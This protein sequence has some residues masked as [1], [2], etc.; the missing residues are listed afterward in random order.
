LAAD[1]AS[2]A[3]KCFCISR[4]TVRSFV[5]FISPYLHS[6]HTQGTRHS[7]ESARMPCARECV[8]CVGYI[9]PRTQTSKRRGGP[10]GTR[11]KRCGRRGRSRTCRMGWDGMRWDTMG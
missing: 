1:D 3:A 9:S 7:E 6:D 11:R 4:L 8:H 10:F 5:S 2:S